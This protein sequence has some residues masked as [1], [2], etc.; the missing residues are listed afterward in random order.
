MPE[1]RK[2]VVCSVKLLEEIPVKLSRR[3]QASANERRRVAGNGITV[4][5][6]QPEC[7]VSTFKLQVGQICSRFI[8]KE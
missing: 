1:L 7:A 3:L 5:K 2:V 8:I 6:D 4:R